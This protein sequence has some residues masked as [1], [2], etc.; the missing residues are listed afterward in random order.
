[1]KRRSKAGTCGG[2]PTD[3]RGPAGSSP[4]SVP[5]VKRL[6]GR[7]RRFPG[8]LF[9]GDPRRRRGSP[10]C[11]PFSPLPPARTSRRSPARCTTTARFCPGAAMARLGSRV[12]GPTAEPPPAA[13]P[14]SAPDRPGA[15]PLPLAPPRPGPAPGSP[16]PASRCRGVGDGRLG[17]AGPVPARGPVLFPGSVPGLRSARR[18]CGAVSRAVRAAGGRPGALRPHGVC[19][20]FP[21]GAMGCGEK[22]EIS[23]PGGGGERSV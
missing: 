11:L 7:T 14:P 3:A 23:G 5:A 2:T 21:R 13:G 4:R 1:M 6:A 19:A 10:V 22:L 12:Q 15:A 9:L 8:T 16:A 17:A 18:K 20:P